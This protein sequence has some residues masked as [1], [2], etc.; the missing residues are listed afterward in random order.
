MFLLIFVNVSNIHQKTVLIFVSEGFQDLYEQLT[1][2]LAPWNKYVL[3][4]DY[5]ISWST[6]SPH[7]IVKVSFIV[8]QIN[9]SSFCSP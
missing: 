8:V 2:T 3:I 4:S 1:V 9:I 6:F 7:A 5:W